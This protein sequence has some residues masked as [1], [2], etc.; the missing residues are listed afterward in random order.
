MGVSR[1][2]NY[3]LVRDDAG[4]VRMTPAWHMSGTDR[5]G[6]DPRDVEDIV[7]SNQLLSNSTTF[8]CQCP[9]RRQGPLHR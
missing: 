3:F 4:T 8:E 1:L 9:E 6:R 5:F 2:G 7:Y